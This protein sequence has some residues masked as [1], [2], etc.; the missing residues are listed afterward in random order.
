MKRNLCLLPGIA[1]LA[2]ALLAE[3]CGSRKST[4]LIPPGGANG[5]GI[6][7][8]TPSPASLSSTSVTN[9]PSALLSVDAHMPGLR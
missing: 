5:A 1:L 6:L 9:E 7:K 8:A 4:A 2:S 3:S